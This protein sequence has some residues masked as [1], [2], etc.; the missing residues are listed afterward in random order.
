M[1]KADDL[2]F[3]V[4]KPALTALNLCNPASIALLA[5]T[6]AAESLLGAYLLQSTYKP[7]QD[8]NSFNGGLGLF[9]M[10]ADDHTDIIKNFLPNHPDLARLLHGFY[11]T[12]DEHFLITDLIYA[13]MFCRIHYL[14][15]SEP[16]PKWDDI[17]G[18]ANYWKTHY[19]SSLGAGDVQHF[20]NNYNLVQASV[21]KL[22]NMGI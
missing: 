16:L 2:I 11:E 5:G 3:A 22:V 12:F 13:A 18:L 15:N 6:C 10:Q 14:R 20:V 7:G 19:N 4:I 8:L 1:M 21:S 17:I 9:Q